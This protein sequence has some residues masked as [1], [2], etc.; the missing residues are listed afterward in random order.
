V[1]EAMA[2]MLTSQDWSENSSAMKNQRR[3]NEGLQPF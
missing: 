2:A 1:G 3:A